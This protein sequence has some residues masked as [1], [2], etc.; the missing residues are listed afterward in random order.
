[1][2][3]R[4]GNQAFSRPFF[5]SGPFRAG[6]RGVFPRGRCRGDNWRGKWGVFSARKVLREDSAREWGIFSA[7]KVFWIF[8]FAGKFLFLAIA[9]FKK[10]KGVQVFLFPKKVFTHVL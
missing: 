1:M 6:L 4:A 5:V 3:I 2:C 10:S 7:R 8:V 9:L